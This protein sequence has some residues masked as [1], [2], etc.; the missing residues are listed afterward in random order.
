MEEAIMQAK[1]LDSIA[2]STQ[3]AE[4]AIEY[5]PRPKLQSCL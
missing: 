4:F 1:V 3:L 5:E 2:Q